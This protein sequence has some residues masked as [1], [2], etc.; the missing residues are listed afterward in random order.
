LIN[1]E[2]HPFNFI[3]LKIALTPG[4][5]SVLL[6]V[7]TALRFFAR[8]K[9]AFT[10]IV[11]TMAL[12]LAANTTV[13]AVLHSFLFSNLAVPEVD[14]VVVVWTTKVQPGSGRVDFVDARPNYL[15]LRE[16][17][18]SFSDLAQS[19]AVDANWEQKEDT[20][21]LQGARVT[22]TFFDVM[23]TRPI[24]GRLF[25]EKEEGPHAAPIALISHALWRHAFAGAANAI[26]Q[27]IRLN[28]IP[29][30]I[31]GV[32]PA[33]FD[34]PTDTDVWLPFDLPEAQWTL[35]TG[36]RQCSTYARLAPG[37]S[38]AAADRELA[39]FASRAIAANPANKDWGWRAQPLKEVLLSGSDNVVLLVQ[40]GAAVL[41]LLAICNL[42]SLLIAWATERQRETAVR[43]ALGAS[44]WRIVRQFL[45]QSV[46]LVGTGGVIGMVIAWLA[47]PALQ[48]LDPDPSLASLLRNVRF[49]PATAIF[50]FLL[51][52]ITG[53][54]VGLIPARQ[55]RATSLNEALRSET[56]GGSAG[57]KSIRWQQAM[58]V[59]QAAISV[60]ILV[61]T[62]IA[63]LGLA[64][65]NRIS[66][67]FEPQ[68]RVALRIGFPEPAM[69][70]HENRAQFVSVFEQKL[71]Q[72]PS[73]L[74]FGLT[75]TLP[76]GDGASGSGFRPQ[77][78]TGEFAPEPLQFHYRRVSPG[79]LRTMGIPIVEGRG[80]EERDRPD[81]LP[82]AVVS[83]SLAQRY[84]P[85]QSA[86]GRKLR[87]ASTQYA[88][89]VEIVG[90]V[91][92]VQESGQVRTKETVYV[93]FAQ[94]SQRRA[95]VVV[96]ARGSLRDAVAGARRALR[97]AGPE[98]AAYDIAA[99]QTLTRQTTA[100]PRLQVFLLTVFALIAIGITAFGTYGV[101]SQLFATRQRELS[102]RG[103]LGATAPSLLRL[104]L[105][106]NARLAIAGTVI[107]S[108]VAWLASRWLQS[109]LT[110]FEPSGVWE[111]AA[112]A[113]GVLFLTQVASLL[114][115]LRATR[116][117]V[118][119]LL[120][121]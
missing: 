49:D 102:I 106:Q 101:M 15:L 37:I 70:T 119:T 53:V 75:T 99:V 34:Q 54:L 56:R 25:T 12:A 50:A 107:G 42:T 81:T 108:V 38:V 41:L 62:T 33:G 73:I 65:L 35:V 100:L 74:S 105:W 6:D 7:T 31:I 82:V 64:K 67:G 86:L 29:H 89:V 19:V 1:E 23:R 69:A 30:T 16:I 121:S 117:D 8:R 113:A 9:A 10:V 51:I 93:P 78:A 87:R 98:V 3:Q 118:R 43:L 94:A 52:I 97:S 59:F 111:L 39:S 88:P 2:L 60:L 63:G 13:F 11:L 83:Q 77:L 27:T 85:G 109:K 96:Q 76:V 95:S 58:V 112:V 5:Q 114:P 22:A 18:R 68:N 26:G 44:T 47:I 36:A 104:V 20:R 84:W 45:V 46:I 120:S 21:R 57:A 32:M 103:A 116:L 61:C 90:V 40:G 48:R 28:G 115:A 71:A 4:M 92:D 24:M 17:T 110:S 91:G 66:L 79:Y 14:R 72:E 55:T 80:V